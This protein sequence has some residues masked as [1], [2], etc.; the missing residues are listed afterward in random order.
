[1]L[2]K[3][4]GGAA[5]N[6]INLQKEGNQYGGRSFGTAFAPLWSHAQ[7]NKKCCSTVKNLWKYSESVLTEYGKSWSEWWKTLQCEF[8]SFRPILEGDAVFATS[9]HFLVNLSELHTEI[10]ERL[11]FWNKGKNEHDHLWRCFQSKAPYKIVKKFKLLIIGIFSL[12]SFQN[13]P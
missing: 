1:M 13:L 8:D 3:L 5:F 9:Y 2:T 7:V 4:P 11:I 12:L 6:M 10:F